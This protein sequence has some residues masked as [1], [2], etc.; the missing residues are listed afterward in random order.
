MPV[1]SSAG[2]HISPRQQHSQPIAATSSRLAS[3]ARSQRGSPASRATGRSRRIGP[4]L[5]NFHDCELLAKPRPSN[6]FPEPRAEALAV[7]SS[8]NLCDQATSGRQTT[9]STNKIM[10]SIASTPS[11]C[12]R[13]SPRSMA[14]LMIGTQAW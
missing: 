6:P 13:P 10:P 2:E 7:S 1:S 4:P 9:W 3:D 14:G 8:V 11:S 12:A 5:K